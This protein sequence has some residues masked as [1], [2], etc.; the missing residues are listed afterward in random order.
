MSLVSN[1]N[2][3]V[4]LYSNRKL[5]ADT[6]VDIIL[7]PEFYWLRVFDIPVKNNTQ[8][9]NVVA[10]LFEDIVDNTSDLSYQVFKLEDGKYM[11]YAYSNKKIYEAIKN[12]GISTSLV[13]AVYFAQN[14][15]NEF[16]SFR[17]DGINFVYTDDDILVKLPKGVRD[18][19]A[20]NLDEK[21]NSINLSS[22]KVDIKFYSNVLSTKYIYFIVAFLAIV[23][24]FNIVKVFSYS[25][26]ASNIDEQITSIKKKS[27]LPSS[28]FQTKS[29]LKKYKSKI[30][31][32]LRKREV[33]SYILQDKKF[34][35]NSI[36]LE[37]DRLLLVFENEDKNKVEKYI[38]KKYKISSINTKNVF[39]NVRIKL[40]I[41]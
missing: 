23:S 12:S 6:K 10:T 33:L 7:S 9:K 5:L 27:S 15:C 26:S 8:A 14:E 40:W 1:K 29:I 35:L 13:N 31:L 37:K 17:V 25:S 20:I 41:N 19:E 11:C 34:N 22:N 32:E 39:L 16:K 3:R 21:I 30:D 36:L 4:F 28:S 2:K 38:S 24:F 18:D